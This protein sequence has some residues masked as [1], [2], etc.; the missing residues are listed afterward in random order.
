MKSTLISHAMICFLMFLPQ[1]IFT[2]KA[3]FAQCCMYSR[4][5]TEFELVLT[6]PHKKKKEMKRFQF[7]CNSL[8]VWQ[9]DFFLYTKLLPQ[10]FLSTMVKAFH[11]VL[12]T[13]IE[14]WIYDGRIKY[15]NS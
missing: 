12:A 15:L 1:Y 3:F 10:Y 7:L 5:Y 13:H 8:S 6:D 11:I 2:W 14:I 9:F 4:L